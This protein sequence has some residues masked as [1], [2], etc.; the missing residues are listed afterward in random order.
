MF[1]SI[2]K[3]STV[4]ILL[5]GT[6]AVG[7]ALLFP[8]PASNT[9]PAMPQMDV[10]SAIADPAGARDIAA[11]DVVADQPQTEDAPAAQVQADT[12]ADP[13]AD[14]DPLDEPDVASMD[15]SLPKPADASDVGVTSTMEEPV[16]QN[17]QTATLE[18]P[19]EESQVA[20]STQTAEAPAAPI[21][22][23][24]TPVIDVVEDAPAGEAVI[25][26]DNDVA[27]TPE[28]DEN[29]AEPEAD[30]VLDSNPSAQVTAPSVISIVT[31]DGQ[32]LPAG[33]SSVQV[34]RPVDDAGNVEETTVA[35]APLDPDAPAMTRYG[36]AFE[37]PEGKPLMSV[38]LLD[39]GEIS[40]ASLALSQ[41]SFPV[42]IVIEPSS[43]GA[44]EKMR[45]YRDIGLEVAVMAD[46][47]QGS[48]PAD[49]EVILG[50]VFSDFP[51]AI[52]L[53]DTGASGL[54]A[55]SNV[56][57]QAMA[58]LAED[59]RGLL[60]ISRGLN[61][62]LRTADELGVPA[63]TIYRDID[64]EW[65]S[66]RVIRRFLD[67]A[68]FRAR[69]ES[70]VVLFGRLRPNTLTALKN[71]GQSSRAEQIA[72]APLTAVLTEKAVK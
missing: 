47:P 7:L 30:I 63:T 71:W 27:M 43:E 49:A 8:A 14:T 69:Q 13:Q 26:A 35:S 72:L 5:S 51:E 12:P 37:N 9:P 54:Q 29:T 33:D 66:A 68:A 36:G 61:T 18:P 3:G 70:G 17:P 38:V 25:V 53:I 24:E 59:G 1:K 15:D 42:T 34:N 4:G 39:R 57:D 31:E 48:T 44:V 56:I 62:A 60:T 65:Q 10:P 40:D 20:I 58:I 41:L 45:L 52:G 22:V 32:S 11:L 55:E 64:I 67:Q 16:L 2:L 46:F 23:D 6:A 19:L 50:S 28:V 21:M